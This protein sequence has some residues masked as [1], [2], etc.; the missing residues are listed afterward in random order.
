M[1]LNGGRR[2]TPLVET[3]KRPPWMLII[4]LIAAGVVI[5]WVIPNLRIPMGDAAG[6]VESPRPVAQAEV[7][8]VKREDLIEVRPASPDVVPDQETATVRLPVEAPRW[9][10]SP[11]PDY[12][13]EGISV[14]G[15]KARVMIGCVVQSNQGLGDCVILREDPPGYG[16]GVAALRA[17]RRAR[18]TEDIQPG[19]RV[20]YTSRFV[21][22]E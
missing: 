22:P 2:P 15:G 18:V 4:L 3:P 21:M 5:A 14:P 1:D 7:E 19:A 10:R 17:T 12:P 9:E 16:F 13:R 6:E 11:M 20:A 8:V